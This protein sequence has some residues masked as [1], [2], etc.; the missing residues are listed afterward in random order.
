MLNKTVEEIKRPT[1]R[2][3]RDKGRKKV[4]KKAQNLETLKIQ[5][6]PVDSILPNKYN[7]NRQSDH[8]FELLCRSIE[9]DGFTQPIIVND[10]T[11]APDFFNFIVDGEHRWRAARALG[12]KQ[13]PIVYVPFT[14]EQMKISTLRHNRARGSE[15]IELSAQVLR[16]LRELGALDHAMDSLML[17]DVEMQRLLDDIPAPEIMQAEEYAQAWEP[18]EIGSDG[19]APNSGIT[20]HSAQAIEAIRDQER[21]IQQA[22]T[23]EERTQAK[24]DSNIQRLSLV[25]S[26]E[27]WVIINA[28]LGNKP[29][30]TLYEL[31]ARELAQRG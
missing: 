5:Y 10:G 17:D 21:R 14:A 16:D 15:D 25:F 24:R 19:S 26:Q 11:R 18:Q 4:E 6:V 9:E 8:D 1:A 20:H 22:K 3:L 29:A 2:V 23:E 28:V 12:F 13:V 7:P 30:E 27:Q 31:C